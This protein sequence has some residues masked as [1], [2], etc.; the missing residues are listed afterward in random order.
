MTITMGAQGEKR[1]MTDTQTAELTILYGSQTGNAEY[2]AHQIHAK[3]AK[4]GEQVELASL[5]EWLHAGPPQTQRLLVVTSTHDNGH[6]P[7]NAAEFWNWLQSLDGGALSGLPYAVLSIG[8]SMYDDFCKA[9][10]DID[11]R[12]EQ[13]GAVR[14]VEGV[15]CDIDFEFTAAKWAGPAVEELLAAEPWAGS[16][17]STGVVA[18]ESTPTSD[19]ASTARIADARTLSK[20]G[21]AK[22][23]TH[24]ELVFDTAF[25]YE[26]GDSI[27]I[28]PTNSDSLVDD[29]ISRYGDQEV[30]VGQERRQLRDVLREDVE[31]RLP[32]PGL[33]VGLARMKPDSKSIRNVL[34]LIQTGDRERLDAWLWSRDVLDVLTDLDCLD[35]PIADVIAELRPLQHRDYSIA[36]SPI[37]D[38][39][40]VHLTVNGV[41]YN[42]HRGPYRGAATDFLAA[43]ARDGM[44]FPVRRLPAHEFRLPGE[45]EP[46]IMIGPGVGIAPFRAFLRHRRALGTSGSNWLFFGDQHRRFDWLYEDEFGELQEAGVLSRI[47]VAF[48]RDQ[49]E[50]HYVQ[51]EI[52]RG[53]AE[54]ADWID[55]GAYIFVC[56]DK[57]SMAPDVD[58][59]LTSV[60]AAATGSEAGGV[61]ALASL[62]ASGRYVKDVY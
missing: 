58:R 55:R 37:L 26:P 19:I 1:A 48:S 45:N 39:G 21:S 33:I 61:E 30:E 52:L 60:L 34:A 42:G 57:T 23:V 27:A 5:E 12:L 17:V 24:Y 35:V 56:G 32:H 6:M 2:L 28:F 41:V 20:T 29:W 40:R 51:D 13:S 3:A 16:A 11:G 14:I 50:K 59:A 22:Q 47:D 49:A 8:D 31:L 10:H 44:P 9:G 53:S 18:A 43:R 38:D 54:I 36:S 15:D 7:D 46:V 25:E 62:K 4:S